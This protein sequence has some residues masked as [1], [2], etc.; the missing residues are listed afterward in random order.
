MNETT[1]CAVVLTYNRRHLLERCLRTL[2]LQ[3][4]RPDRILVV[5]NAGSDGT[6]EFLRTR[7]PDV[8]V[9]VLPHNVGAAGGFAQGMRR[10]HE[11]GH[12]WLWV[13]DDDAYP[14]PDA[15]EELL[16]Y[17]APDRVLVPWQRDRSGR[18]YG[19]LDWRERPVTVDPALVRAPREVDL[20]AF[21]GALVPATAVGAHGLPCEDYFI[22]IFDWEYGLRLRQAGLKVLLVPSSVVEHDFAT[23]VER[24]VLGRF[25]RPRPRQAQPAWKEYYFNRNYLVTVRRRSLGWG[26]AARYVC[27]Q[28]LEMARDVAFQPDGWRRVRLRLHAVLDGL[29]GLTGRRDDLAAPSTAKP[30]AGEPLPPERSP[31]PWRPEE[32]VTPGEP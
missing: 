3:T 10:A 27:R 12:G 8:E 25:G 32:S 1:V 18:L 13:M 30:S 26:A 22:D 24:R 17:A 28:P 15:L 21:V 4:R 11:A 19:A 9:L 23:T 29:R 31:V 5:D 20:I 6:P 2:A 7:F 14:L 16:R